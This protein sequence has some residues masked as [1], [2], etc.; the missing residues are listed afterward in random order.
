[1]P[2]T[3]SIVQRILLDNFLLITGAAGFIGFHLSKSLLDDDYEVLGIDNINDYYDP[4]LNYARLDQLTPYNYF[5]F[6]KINI[7]DRKSL[8]QS[9]KL[10]KVVNLAVQVGERYR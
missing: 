4:K 9:F 2:K 5:M 6:K 7:A 1:M 8:T 3:F 10:Q